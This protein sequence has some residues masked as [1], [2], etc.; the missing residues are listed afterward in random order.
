VDIYKACKGCILKAA[1]G[2]NGF[3]LYSGCEISLG[4]PKQNILSLI[5]ASKIL[6]RGA[7]IGRLP[8]G[9]VKDCYK[10]GYRFFWSTLR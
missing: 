1:E 2:P 9:V 4:R 7:Q 3:I 10:D 8:E 5:E 6:G